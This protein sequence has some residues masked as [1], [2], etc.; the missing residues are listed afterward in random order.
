MKNV[1]ITIQNYGSSLL[2]FIQ[3]NTPQDAYERWLSLSNWGATRQREGEEPNF[4]H[5]NV[6]SCWTTEEKLLAYFARINLNRLADELGSKAK[7]VKGG[8]MPQAIELAK[9]QIAA[10]EVESFRSVNSNFVEHEF[11]TIEAEKPDEDLKDFFILRGFQT[12]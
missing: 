7:G 8:L 4:V 10:L 3:G 6:I 1:K 5:D 11:G 12:A 9:Q 2:L